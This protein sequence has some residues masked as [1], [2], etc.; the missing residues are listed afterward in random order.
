M[1]KNIYQIYMLLVC[2]FSIIV[3]TFSIAFSLYDVLDL[4]APEYTH[5]HTLAKY[6]SDE[7][8]LQSLESEEDQMIH[9][10]PQELSTKRE[11]AK[12][13][14]LKEIKVSAIG[15]LMKT[16]IWLFVSVGLFIIHWRLFQKE[17]VVGN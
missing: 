15:G 13:S 11:H 7:A 4:V 16:F 5:S 10:S 14:E 12:V 9:V 6:D 3:M 17:K 1:T 2:F 8:Y